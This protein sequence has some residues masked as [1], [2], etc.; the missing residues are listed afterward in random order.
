LEE[1]LNTGFL[2]IVLAVFALLAAKVHL[3]RA[4]ADYVRECVAQGAL[5]LD[6][7]SRLEYLE[8]HLP[9]AINVPLSE[10]KDRIANVAPNKEQI[11]LL[12]CASGSRSEVAKRILRS[13]GYRNAHNV[14]SYSRARA[15][16][17]RY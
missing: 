13:I 6:V 2:W 12:Y 3:C 1:I 11:L 16:L 17:A 8:G 14:G 10:L 4:R 15:L 9:N 7:R 5:V